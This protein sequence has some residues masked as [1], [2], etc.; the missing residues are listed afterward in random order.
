MR[1]TMIALV[2]ALVLLP[3]AMTKAKDVATVSE[4]YMAVCTETREH[5]GQEYALTAWLDSR[6]AANAA[7]KEH[8]R[9]TRG[10]RWTL[11]TREK[12]AYATEPS[13]NPAS[14]QTL[15]GSVINAD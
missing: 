6:D 10:H 9:A 15:S 13:Q 11:R 1:K 14:A 7:A 12:P 2:S 8:E 4:Q 5:G 3:C